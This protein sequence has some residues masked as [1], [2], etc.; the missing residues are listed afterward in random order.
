MFT[1]SLLELKNSISQG[2]FQVIVRVL[3]RWLSQIAPAFKIIKVEM[4]FL[5]GQE[6]VKELCLQFI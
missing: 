3:N 2:N 1:V 4:G 5:V 6:Q